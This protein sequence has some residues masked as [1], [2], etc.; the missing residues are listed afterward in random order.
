M[1]QAHKTPGALVEFLPL[2]PSDAAEIAVFGEY[3]GRVFEVVCEVF[4][5]HFALKDVL[6]QKILGA[7]LEGTFI[8][9]GFHPERLRTV[10]KARARQVRAVAP[11]SLA[12]PPKSAPLFA[13]PAPSFAFRSR[14]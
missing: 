6:T 1:T 14:R 13:K 8:A 2:D 3:V 9:A 7:A 10:P 5:G 4:P 11:L 12:P